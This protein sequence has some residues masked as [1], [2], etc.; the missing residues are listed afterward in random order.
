[1]LPI[2]PDSAGVGLTAF[3]LFCALLIGHAFADFPLQ[4][5]FLASAKNRHNLPPGISPDDPCRHR[6]WIYAMS[7]HCAVHAGFV[8]VITGSWVLAMTEF[9]AHWI[10]DLLKCEDITNFDADQTLHIVTKAVM[11]ALVWTGVVSV[12]FW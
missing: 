1:M 4:G 7:A 11:I 3:L 8:W 12:P 5:T 2:I 10:I 9:V 6:I